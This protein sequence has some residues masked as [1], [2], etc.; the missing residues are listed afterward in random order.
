MEVSGRFGVICLDAD[1]LECAFTQER[2]PV[3][4]ILLYGGPGRPAGGR[5][6]SPQASGFG[7]L[8][9]SPAAVS[10]PG[11]GRPLIGLRVAPGR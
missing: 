8:P 10:A 7:G 1:D 9:V 2:P 11:V 4:E 3:P 6:I 5:W